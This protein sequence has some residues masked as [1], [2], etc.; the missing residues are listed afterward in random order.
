MYKTS[1]FSVPVEDGDSILVYQT[2]TSSLIRLEPSVYRSL[3]E[4]QRIPNNPQQVEA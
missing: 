2:L 4:E 3:F 1:I